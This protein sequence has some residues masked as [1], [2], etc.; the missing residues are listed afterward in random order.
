MHAIAPSA[1]VRSSPPCHAQHYL[2][3]AGASKDAPAGAHRRRLFFARPLSMAGD[4]FSPG[5]CVDPP[6]D[7]VLPLSPLPAEV[8]EL[9]DARVSKTREGNLMRVRFPPSAFSVWTGIEPKG[10]L[11]RETVPLETPHSSGKEGG[12]GVR[13][14]TDM[15]GKPRFPFHG[16]R[17][18]PSDGSFPSLGIFRLDGNRTGAAS[19]MRVVLPRCDAACIVNACG[20]CRRAP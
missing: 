2:T 11:E 6:S 17:R 20:C 10:E 8:A 12:A 15:K 3:T 14:T 19:T 7:G 13:R 9:A 4:V 1:V 18:Q 16:A 5:A